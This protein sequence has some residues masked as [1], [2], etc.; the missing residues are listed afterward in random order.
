MSIRVVLADDA[1]IVRKAIRK[2][3]EENPEISIV[4][5]A[6]NIAETLKLTSDRKPGHPY[7]LTHVQRQERY[8]TARQV[9]VRL[10]RLACTGNVDLE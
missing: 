5:E 9:P 7:G 8:T 4:G 3:L 6:D 10:I 1:E 2:L